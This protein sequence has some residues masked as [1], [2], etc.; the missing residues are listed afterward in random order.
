M[1]KSATLFTVLVLWVFGSVVQAQQGQRWSNHP[2]CFPI[3]NPPYL[4]VD[5]HRSDNYPVDADDAFFVSSFP[6]QSSAT[7]ATIEP[8]MRNGIVSIFPQGGSVHQDGVNHV[9]FMNYNPFSFSSPDVFA[10]E[11]TTEGSP[12]L[13]I[14]SDIVVNNDFHLRLGGFSGTAGLD[15]SVSETDG[16]LPS[17]FG[18][19]YH[20]QSF[21]IHEV[22]HGLG[23]GHAGGS[24][25]MKGSINIR[26]INVETKIGDQA[27]MQ[28]RYCDSTPNDPGPSGGCKVG[29]TV[30][31]GRVPVALWTEGL[32]QL[33]GS[34]VLEGELTRAVYSRDIATALNSFVIK[35]LK[36]LEAYGTRTR[37]MTPAF[38]EG[39]I[40]LMNRVSQSASADLSHRLLSFSARLSEPNSP[41]FLEDAIEGFDEPLPSGFELHGLYPNPANNQASIEFS[42]AEP[43]PVRVTIYDV[44]G[45]AKVVQPGG[46]FRAGP[47]QLRLNT[48]G[49]A[50]GVYLVA[51]EVG[52]EEPVAPMTLVIR[53]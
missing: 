6:W 39:F 14:E 22:G 52:L 45:R 28:Q 46:V 50:N 15:Y 21:L 43:S 10:I 11:E 48:R 53:R 27:Q 1:K 37:S 9:D 51:V 7:D 19:V 20:F 40:D 29:L 31:A 44:T 5:Y 25:L 2:G 23:L 49:L 12:G 3:P 35:N 42:L 36:T 33:A 16:T 24:D 4:L 26:E 34:S 13:I 17:F 30:A 47:H 8:W 41:R 32:S 38:K 18:E